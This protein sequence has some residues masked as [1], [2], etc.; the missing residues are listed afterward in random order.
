MRIEAAKSDAEKELNK[1]NDEAEKE[2]DLKI[3]DANNAI[4]DEKGKALKELEEKLKKKLN[5][6]GETVK[7]DAATQVKKGII[8]I[9]FRL[10]YPKGCR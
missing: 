7:P 8:K 5:P 4:I 6:D 2:V 3:E 1:L 9:K 10:N